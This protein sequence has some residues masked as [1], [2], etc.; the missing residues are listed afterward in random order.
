MRTTADFIAFLICANYCNLFLSIS[1]FIFIRNLKS[2]LLFP[3]YRYIVIGKHIFARE[4]EIA[5]KKMSLSQGI[6][7]TAGG[8]VS[9]AQ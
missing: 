6:Y 9:T 3:F 1:S 5:G 2:R 8:P 4:A 7:S